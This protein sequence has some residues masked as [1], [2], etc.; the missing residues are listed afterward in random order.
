MQ[1]AVTTVAYTVR[2]ATAEDADIIASHRA[3]MFRDMGQ[4]NAEEAAVMHRASRPWLEALILEGTY[5]GWLIALD[6]TIVGGGGLHLR[7]FGPVPGHNN[8][9]MAAH[10][11]NV[12][13]EPNHRNRGLA[14][15]LMEL[16]MEWARSEGISELTL[17]ASDQAKPLYRRLGFEPRTDSYSLKL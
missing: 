4:L 11:G 6:S 8:V 17:S 9:G 3:L 14:K 13:I 10:I 16:M 1:E 5:K 2:P 15:M 7:S 12:Y